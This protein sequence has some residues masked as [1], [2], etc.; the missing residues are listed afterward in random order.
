M[1]QGLGGRWRRLIEALAKEGALAVL[2]AAA[3]A[4]PASAQAAITTYRGQTS[5]QDYTNDG[6]DNGVPQTFGFNFDGSSVFDVVTSTTLHCPDGEFMN[7]GVVPNMLGEPFPSIGGHFDV[8]IGN[9]NTGNG[10]TVHL[11]G[12][13]ANGQASGTADAQAHE[14]SG[15]APDGP[16][17]TA[18]FTWTAS[19]PVTVTPPPLPSAPSPPRVQLTPTTR[20][21][22]RPDAGITIVALRTLDGRH[23]FWGVQDAQCING[24]THLVF[25]IGHS[26]RR[27]KCRR[28]IT[29][30][31]SS[32]LPHRYYLIRV[33]VVRIR[34]HRLTRGAAY[35]RRLYMPGNEALWIP[36]PGLHL[37]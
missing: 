14:F 33:R 37:P 34:K 17:C 30:V 7:M 32:V 31:S 12:N 6:V 24:A 36:V 5:P 27:V 23:Y 3:L 16:I 15:V 9:P 26:R 20:G 11:V 2:V 29:V 1:K 21:H 22:R 18:S 19:A 35:S 13:I 4:L 8:T 25:R 28:Q 10:F